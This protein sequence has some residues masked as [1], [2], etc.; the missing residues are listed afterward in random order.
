MKI[1]ATVE[2]TEDMEVDIDARDTFAE[3]VNEMGPGWALDRINDDG[4]EGDIDEYCVNRVASDHELMGKAV[5]LLGFDELMDV[6]KSEHPA[7]YD[8]LASGVELPDWLAAVV[9]LTPMAVLEFLVKATDP[10]KT[11]SLVIQAQD[12]RIKK[13]EA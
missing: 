4:F 12:E 7:R 5:A 10:V 9:P 8:E 2:I 6:V 3:I 1:T 13:L 11:L